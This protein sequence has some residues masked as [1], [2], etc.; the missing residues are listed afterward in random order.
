M[1]IKMKNRYLWVYIITF[2]LSLLFCNSQDFRYVVSSSFLRNVETHST[3]I[4]TFR[5]SSDCCPNYLNGNSDADI[6][7]LS[8]EIINPFKLPNIFFGFELGYESSSPV[9]YYDE[10]EEINVNG[11]PFLGKI[12]HSANINLINITGGFSLSYFDNHWKLS[13]SVG[14]KFVSSNSVY[15]K[16]EIIV[17]SDRGVFQDTQTRIKN[18]FNGALLQLNTPVIIKLDVAYLLPL[19][20]KVKLYIAPAAGIY[21]QS[22]YL[23]NKIWESYGYGFGINL[24]YKF[25]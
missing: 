12:R 17:P 7:N 24:I 10:S 2:F 16:Q 13:T 5:D 19:S 25:N 22:S 6:F 23:K 9:L 1:K 8:F 15:E 18:E 14:L 11:E 3:N 21:F 4:L 20:K